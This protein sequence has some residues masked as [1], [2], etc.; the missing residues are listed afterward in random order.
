MSTAPGRLDVGVVSAG[1]A[2]AV[3]GGALLASGHRGVGVTARSE[4]SRDR[5][6]LLMAGVPVAEP[7]E[8]AARSQLL[9]LAV[10]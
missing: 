9:V 4:A 2:G 7:G 10:P 1:R 8:V 5:A 3:I 6:E